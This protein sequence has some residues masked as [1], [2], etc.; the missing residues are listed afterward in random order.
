MSPQITGIVALLVGALICFY[1]YPLFRILL[2]V[3]G[4]MVGYIVGTNLAP[5]QPVL[6]LVIAVVLAVIGALLA[7]PLWS[8]FITI[9][10]ALLGG[11]IG[12]L[13]A[14]QLGFLNNTVTLLIFVAVGAVLFGVLFNSVRDLMVMLNTAINGALLMIYGLGLVIGA[15]LQSQDILELVVVAVLA[16]FGFLAQ[17]RFFRNSRMYS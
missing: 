1:G 14:A 8:L 12:Y 3:I 2:P 13:L 15:D 5:D 6:A 10:G 16:T 9:G 17:Y 7:Y 11:S 4:F